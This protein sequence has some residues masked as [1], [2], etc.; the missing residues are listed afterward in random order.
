[1]RKLIS[2]VG[3]FAALA[4]MLGM[5]LTSAF[6]G[7]PEATR[8]NLFAHPAIAPAPPTSKVCPGCNMR[9]TLTQFAPGSDLCVDCRD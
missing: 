9:R 8:G 2:V 3:I 7:T 4:L 5:N 1:M 6:A